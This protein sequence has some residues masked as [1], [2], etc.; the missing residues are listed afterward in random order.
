MEI[1]RGL[2]GIAFFIGIAY[3]ISGNK[4]SIDWRL[5]GIGITLQIVFDY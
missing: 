4:K 1:L 3:L 5:V 2:V